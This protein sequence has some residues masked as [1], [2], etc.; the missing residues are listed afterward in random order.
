MS[1]LI[2]NVYDAF[3]SLLAGAHGLIEI[4][5]CLRS[6]P[7]LQQAFGNANSNEEVFTFDFKAHHLCD[8]SIYCRLPRS[9]SCIRRFVSFVYTRDYE[10]ANFESHIS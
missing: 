1:I 9:G 8:L 6:D 3:I 7:A 4:N 2:D 10:S 5:T